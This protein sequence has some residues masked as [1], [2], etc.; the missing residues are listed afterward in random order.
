MLYRS[1]ASLVPLETELKL[2]DDYVS[3]EKLRFE[4][5]LALQWNIEGPVEAYAIAPFL[6][7]P[8]LENAFKHGFSENT[9]QLEL[10]V[11]AR[12]E[13]GTL[14]FGV[15]NSIAAEA[16]ARPLIAGGIGLKN[17]QKRLELQYPQKHQLDVETR[18]GYYK[19]QLQ[20][21]LN[22]INIRDYA[23]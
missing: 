5:R 3:L 8:F 10:R 22:P 19:I 1:H 14:F 11:E 2:I 21:T 18:N 20:L 12:L 6:L 9:Q 13:E 4:D 15:T 23:S 16:P 7:F 17:V